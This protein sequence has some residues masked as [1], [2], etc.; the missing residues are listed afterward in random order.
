[1]KI[2]KNIPV[3]FRRPGVDT[4]VLGSDTA[5]VGTAINFK[6]CIGEVRGSNLR[7]VTCY[8]GRARYSPIFPGNY[9]KHL[10]NIHEMY[11]LQNTDSSGVIYGK[12]N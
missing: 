11:R 8:I 10:L 1:M 9:L 7:H 3:N 4:S 5:Q 2:W 6:S 12:V